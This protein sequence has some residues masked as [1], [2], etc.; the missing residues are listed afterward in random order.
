MSPR[1]LG[2]RAV[3]VRAFAR[4][5]ETNLKKQ[6]VLPLTFANP[7]DY[8]RIRKDDRLTLRGLDQ[9]AAGKPVTVEIRHVDGQAETIEARHSL[10]AEQIGW[11]QAGSALNQIRRQRQ[12][13]GA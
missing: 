13:T 7:A 8:D 2:C 10:T 6:G 4:I 9:I 3:L 12:K 5:H 11:F 1:F